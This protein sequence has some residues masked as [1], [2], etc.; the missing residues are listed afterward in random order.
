MFW[1]FALLRY[2]IAYNLFHGEVAEWLIAHPWKG[3]IRASVSRVR[4]PPS[5]LELRESGEGA[6][7]LRTLH[8]DSKRRSICFL[9]FIL[10]RKYAS[11]R[12]GVLVFWNVMHT[13]LRT[14]GTNP[15]LTAL[16]ATTIACFIARRRN[17][18]DGKADNVSDDL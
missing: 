7:C 6:T 12:P 1:S 17:A 18:T 5:P 16:T 15:S 3:C 14:P 9:S 2:D 4:I 8:G 13:I 10:E 11:R